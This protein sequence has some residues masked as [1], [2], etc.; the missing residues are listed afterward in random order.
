MT[1]LRKRHAAALKFRTSRRSARTGSGYD[2]AK[3][4]LTEAHEAAKAAHD[5]FVDAAAARFARTA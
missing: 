3:Q 1:I 4:R 5:E 2:A